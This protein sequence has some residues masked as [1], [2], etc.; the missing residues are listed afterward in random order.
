MLRRRTKGDH[1]GMIGTKVDPTPN[2]SERMARVMIV[3][4]T[5]HETKDG[6]I[7]FWRFYTAEGDYA[8]LSGRRTMPLLERE[9]LFMEELRSKA[10][11]YRWSCQPPIMISVTMGRRGWLVSSVAHYSHMVRRIPEQTKLF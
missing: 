1:M 3:S 4:I 6:K 5:C 10:K 8:L 2:G 11:G 7:K 9:S